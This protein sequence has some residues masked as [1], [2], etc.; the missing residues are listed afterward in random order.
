MASAMV[1]GVLHDQV[2]AR[3][4]VEYFTIGHPP[5]FSTE[6][7]TNLAF[8]WGI[9]ASWWV[10]LLLGIPFAFACRLG[11]FPRISARW[12]V[13]PVVSLL[14]TMGIGSLL[15]GTIGYWTAEAGGVWLLEPLRSRVPVEK[16]A[17][18]LADLWAH[19]AAYGFGIVGGIGL[20]G[21]VIY[22][23]C[24]LARTE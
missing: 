18:F 6:D 5:I 21:W 9:F 10:G 23:R 1:Y 7:P 15:A 4:C 19:L 3:V 17:F 16:H 24:L 8:G 13:R 20:C 14:L 22:K 11:S 12:I 2:T